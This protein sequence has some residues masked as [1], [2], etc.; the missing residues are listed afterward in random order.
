VRNSLIRVSAHARKR[1][2]VLNSSLVTLRKRLDDFLV[3]FIISN[4]TLRHKFP[5]YLS[6]RN[7]SLINFVN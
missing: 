6:E 7:N 2:Y 4:L 3:Y 1:L 5:L